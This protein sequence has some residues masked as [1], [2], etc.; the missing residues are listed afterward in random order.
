MLLKKLGLLISL[1][2]INIAVFAQ[3]T[4]VF[5][6]DIIRHGDRTA[7][8]EMPKAPHEWSEGLGQL[9]PIGMQQE[10]QRGMK[11][12]KQYV[13]EFHLL[14]AQFNNK[15]IYIFST[16]SDR[17]LMS[18]QSVLLGLYPLGTGPLIP[19]KNLPALPSRF[20]PIP[21]HIKSKDASEV[22]DHSDNSKI[23]SRRLKKYVFTQ[24]DWQQTIAENKPQLVRWS[25][26]T[27]MKLNNLHQ[28]RHLADILH[29]YQL[30][31]IPIPAGLSATDVK[32]IIA[33]GDEGFV[34]EYQTKKIADIVGTH[35]LATIADYLQ[36]ASTQQTSL[37]YVLFSAHDT[38]IMSVMTLLNAPL[39]IKP[40]YGSD[41]K[42][43]LF[44]TDAGNY[45]VRVTYNDTPVILQACNA[46]DCT[47]SQFLKQAT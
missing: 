31:H 6:F 29:V 5:A 36:Q 17:T 33:L 3:E 15:E 37:K 42:F 10:Y 28:V 2:S 24:A 46:K 8:R 22:T 14:P 12:R 41:L 38:S 20:Q 1:L 32:K 45:V 35:L 13:D 18:A 16:N 30:H 4:L 39:T 21:I 47:L 34:M 27:G 7:L 19:A 40:T 9:T 43:L 11:F 23:F 26:V 25:E 44:K